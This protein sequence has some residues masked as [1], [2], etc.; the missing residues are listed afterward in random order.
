MN[1][2]EFKPVMGLRIEP[3]TMSSAK[4]GGRKLKQK[5]R[6]LLAQDEFASAL[7]ALCRLPA[8][9]VI[10]PLFSFF[11][12]MDEL[13]KWRAVTAVGAVVSELAR[14][15]MEYAR[16]AMRRLIWSLNDESGGIG[17][18]SA[19]AL[20][21]IMARRKELA[22]EYAHL[23]LSYARKDGNF[24]ENELLQRGVLWGLGRLAQA[25]PRLLKEAD[26]FIPPYL[27]STDSIVRGSAVKLSGI[28]CLGTARESLDRLTADHTPFRL[29][30]NGGMVT[31]HINR[32]AAEA[33]FRLNT[34]A[35]HN[36]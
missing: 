35:N 24:I 11:Y 26:I 22:D 30:C 25:Y 18:G 36:D 6:S 29:Y 9:E 3:A 1:G 23:L 12:S 34:H 15:D 32:I 20:G 21:E 33:L 31:H 8:R 10:S 13:T 7:A 19:E 5:I 27:K 14:T 4:I 16:V 28:L 17:W 2:R